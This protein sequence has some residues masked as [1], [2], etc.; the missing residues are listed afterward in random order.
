[1]TIGELIKEW[2][3]EKGLTQKQLAEAAGLAVITVQQ[4]ESGKRIPKADKFARI[5]QVLDIS[6]QDFW[7]AS[8]NTE[9]D[10][11]Y[12]AV[13]IIYGDVNSENIMNYA[14]TSAEAAINRSEIISKNTGIDADMVLTLL[15][16]A[17]SLNLLVNDTYDE[18][19]LFTLSTKFYEVDEIL[20]IFNYIQY[21]ISRRPKE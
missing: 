8:L 17:K 6:E 13:R 10:G 15:E 20:E 18:G 7:K 9:S 1:M 11:F 4:Y 12:D 3:K 16:T 19:M 2:R 21:V 14:K 5:A